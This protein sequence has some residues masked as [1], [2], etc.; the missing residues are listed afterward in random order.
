MANFVPRPTVIRTIPLMG[1][2]ISQIGDQAEVN[3]NPTQIVLASDIAKN[4]KHYLRAALASIMP[5][6]E[7]GEIAALVNL[8]VNGTPAHLVITADQWALGAD[9]RTR[10][11]DWLADT[12]AENADLVA[13][14][15]DYDLVNNEGGE[16]YNPYRVGSKR[17]Y[18]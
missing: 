9:E 14:E 1:L 7:S 5:K 15:I 6:I 18:T 17:T 16:G 2:V 13:K 3:G 12:R 11:A 8:T 10:Y 4:P